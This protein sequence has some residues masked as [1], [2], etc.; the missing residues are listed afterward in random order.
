MTNAASVK[1][2]LKNRSIKTGKTMQELLTAYGL[3]RTLHR[4]SVSKYKENF[5]LKGGIFLYAIFQGDYARATTDIDFLAQRISNEEDDIRAVFSEIFA[6]EIDDPLRYDMDSLVVSSI[7]AFK[8]YHGVRVEVM[9]YLDRTR[10]PISID[11]GFDD[12]IYPKRVEMDYPSILDDDGPGVFAYSI[13][14]V[15]AEKFEAIVSLAY[16]NSRFKDFYDIFV[17]S[18]TLDVNGADLIEAVRETFEHRKTTLAEVV[19]FEPE[20]ATDRL[21]QSRWNY[22]TKKKR[23]MLSVSLEDVIDTI[24]RFMGPV[25]ESITMS[26]AMDAIWDHEELLWLPGSGSCQNVVL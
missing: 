22:F 5:T 3:E 15:I 23:A 6:M 25:V 11:I 14:S 16:D 17:I 4:L 10:I 13:C 12:V 18:K 21:R 19:A 9:A 8:K 1:D 20:F 24:K 7:A 2:R 26:R